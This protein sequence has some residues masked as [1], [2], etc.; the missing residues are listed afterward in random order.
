MRVEKMPKYSAGEKGF[1]LVELLIVVII[2]AVLA[3]VVVPQFSTSTDDAKVS[4]LDSTLSNMRAAIDLYYQQ[5]SGAYPGA[6]TAVGS[7]AVALKGTGTG[8]D[9]VTFQEQ[10]SL[11]TSIT[12]AACGQK[13]T[14]FKY[15][16][17]LKK[18]ILPQNPITEVNTVVIDA[19]ASL[20]MIS[21]TAGGGWKYNYT[22]GQFIADDTNLDA[23]GAAYYT[24]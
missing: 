13:D 22:T 14:V 20:G 10:M 21:T 4:A 19:T 7:C 3:A 12:G 2:L 17:Y 18:A 5:H 15:G 23:A 9:L 11:Y 8:T 16:P 1:T 24:H 6:K